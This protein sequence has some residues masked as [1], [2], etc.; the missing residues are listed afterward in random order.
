MRFW[1]YLIILHEQPTFHK[2]MHV[3]LSGCLDT[4][5]FQPGMGSCTYPRKPII[6]TSMREQPIAIL[7]SSPWPNQV[8]SG[9]HVTCAGL[10]SGFECV[11]CIYKVWHPER[12]CGG[13]QREK[14]KTYIDI[15]VWRPELVT[16]MK[17][18]KKK[19]EKTSPVVTAN[20]FSKLFFR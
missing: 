10:W 9:G 17:K 8:T 18:V 3:S 5:M 13:F 2:Q 11:M 14:E 4:S 12:T 20:C 1:N 7:P 6:G 16:A 19:A 15:S